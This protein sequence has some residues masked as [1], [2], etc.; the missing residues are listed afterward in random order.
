MTL[1]RIGFDV[2]DSALMVWVSTF[3]KDCS[4]LFYCSETMEDYFKNMKMETN[5]ILRMLYLQYLVF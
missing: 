3:I 4:F 2:S 1:Q 5:L